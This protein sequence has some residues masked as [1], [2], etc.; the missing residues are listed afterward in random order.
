MAKSK[1]QVSLSSISKDT[2]V[3]VRRIENGF[4]VS[5]SG[6][7]GNGKNQKYVSKEFFSKT[8]PIQVGSSSGGSI[9][10]GGKK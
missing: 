9:K 7:V 6:Y 8:N 2:S 4:V 3:S 1:T 5:Q 10:F